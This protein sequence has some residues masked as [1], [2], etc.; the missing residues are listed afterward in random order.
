[1]TKTLLLDD[2]RNFVDG[3][4]HTVIRS[5]QEAIQLFTDSPDVEFD[6]MWLDFIL[7]GND[8]VLDFAL[9]AK[10]QALAGS[11]L[12]VKKFIIHTSSGSGYQILKSLLEEDGAYVTERFSIATQNP[13][14]RVIV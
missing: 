3:R 10:K 6:E 7:V 14:S 9:F 5:S 13:Q 1:M 2:E 8:T 11:P 12:K 4:E